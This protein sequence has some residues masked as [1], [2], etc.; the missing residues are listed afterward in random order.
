MSISTVIS[1]LSGAI[2]CFHS[3]LSFIFYR[4]Y[5]RPM[6]GVFLQIGTL[7]Y[8]RVVKANSIM[9]P[10]LSCRDGNFLACSSVSTFLNFLSEVWNTKCSSICNLIACEMIL[11]MDRLFLVL[12]DC[13]FSVCSYFSSYWESC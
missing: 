11:S 5:N 2:S 13:S 8:A 10:G 3:V 4:L 7:I 12:S 6:M 1:T 9:N